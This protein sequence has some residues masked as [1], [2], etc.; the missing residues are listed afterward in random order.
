MGCLF[1]ANN[2]PYEVSIGYIGFGMIRCQLARSFSEKFGEIYEKPYKY[3][4][5]EGFTEEDI[6]ILNHICPKG[7]D[8]FLWFSDAG[9]KISSSECKDIICDLDK[10]P[11]KWPDD[12]RTDWLE[13][14]KKIKELIRWCAKTRHTLYIS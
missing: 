6:E 12:W 13:K 5:F 11:M 3:M 4:F 14:Y 9:G 8:L 10:Y 7:L 1:Y 2:G